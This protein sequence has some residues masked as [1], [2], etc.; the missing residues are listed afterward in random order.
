M[1]GILAADIDAARAASRRLNDMLNADTP[2]HPVTMAPPPPPASS[3]GGL[4][5][6]TF[7]QATKRKRENEIPDIPLKKKHKASIGNLNH[8]AG[9]K[10]Y[11]MK[12]GHKDPMRNLN[13]GV[14]MEAKI[15]T[16]ME[17]RKREQD[18][19][20]TEVI[21]TPKPKPC[22]EIINISDDETDTETE[23]QSHKRM[24]E[25]GRAEVESKLKVEAPRK[26]IEISDDEEEAMVE[27]EP[28]VR[29]RVRFEPRR[30]SGGCLTN[31]EKILKARKEEERQ[32]RKDETASKKLARQ[33]H[34]A[35][36]KVVKHA[37]PKG[38]VNPS[39]KNVK[40][41]AKGVVLPTKKVGSSERPEAKNSR[42]LPNGIK[43]PKKPMQSRSL[44]TE[45]LFDR[46][47]TT[48]H[49]SS[50][51]ENHHT[52]S[53]PEGKRSSVLYRPTARALFFKEQQAA[54]EEALEE[55][56]IAREPKRTGHFR[57]LDLDRKIRDQI[58][59]EVAVSTSC[60]KWPVDSALDG[61]Q[62]DLAM[63]CQQ[64]R[65]EVLPLYYLENRFAISL[66]GVIADDEPNPKLVLL[67]KWLHAIGDLK[68]EKGKWLSNIRRW[69]FYGAVEPVVEESQ[70]DTG[71]AHTT[72]ETVPIA[73][74]QFG[75]SLLSKEFILCLKYRS[76]VEGKISLRIHREAACILPQF[77]ASEVSCVP[78]QIPDTI[79]ELSVSWRKVIGM[80]KLES[81]AKRLTGLAKKLNDLAADLVEACCNVG[82]GEQAGAKSACTV[83]H[84]SVVPHSAVD[85]SEQTKADSKK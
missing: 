28:E 12:K 72:S 47:Q 31:S 85:A 15:K 18:R 9:T 80:R 76:K 56:G 65:K 74:T 24:S 82:S 58:Y 27:S 41:S 1:P 49:V 36:S 33:N 30:S 3:F 35:A 79:R 61:Q 2:N 83:M 59:R 67:E 11:E 64:I 25:N 6:K 40:R 70:G 54:K 81:R 71:P 68:N 78:G 44:L 16:E 66:P 17:G 10:S 7:G 52:S 84:Q 75:R 73:M 62:P 22:P 46:K 5:R 60:F 13:F 63:V 57:F 26:R 51:V 23:E 29:N 37:R 20:S 55:A 45:G 53:V 19:E 34:V 43:P 21:S 42:P 39:I 8:G 48:I 50:F 69:V 14:K 38:N 77:S 4:P 32:K